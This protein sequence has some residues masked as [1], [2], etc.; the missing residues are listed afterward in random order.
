ML[1]PFELLDGQSRTVAL[2]GRRVE[3]LLARLALSPGE[4]VPAGL[5]IDDLWGD[6]PS[7]GGANALQRLVSRARRA[8][9]E[10]GAGDVTVQSGPGGYLLTVAPDEVDATVFEGLAAEGRRLLRESD[11]ARAVEPLRGALELW[12][13]VPLAE[14]DVGFAHAA[15][16]R[17]GELR[18]SATEDL[19]EA[20][21]RLGRSAEAAVELARLCAEHPLRERAAGLLMMALNASGRQTDALGA[22]E[23]IRSALAEELG[24]DPSPWLG[25]LHVGLLRGNSAARQGDGKE[26]PRSEAARLPARLARFVG[27][28]NEL[29]QLETALERSRLTT[30]FGSGGVGKTRLAIEY[31]T[32]L[33]DRTAERIRFVELAPLRAGT[34]LAETVAAALGSGQTLLLDR[35]FPDRNRFDQL[36]SVLSGDPTLLILDNCEHMLDDVVLFVGRILTDCPQLRILATSREPL[37]ITGEALCHIGPLG[38]PENVEDAEGAAAIQLFCDRAALVRPGFAL[39]P[40]TVGA[41]VEICRRLDGLPLAVEL[42]AARLRTMTVRQ[43]ADRLDDRFRLLTGGNRTSGVRHRTLRAVLDWSWD[44]LEEPERVLA[45][46]LSVMAGG[47]TADAAAVVCAGAGLIGDDVLYVLSSL[48]EKSLVQVLEPEPGEVRYRMPETTR[49][50]C[51]ERLV[52]AEELVRT[53]VACTA[54]LLELAERAGTGLHGRD[55][56]RLLALLDAEHD[57]LVQAVQRAVVD[58]DLDVAVRLCLALSWYWVMRGRYAE[59]DRWFGALLRF[60]DGIPVRARAVFAAT[61]VVIPVSLEADRARVTAEAADL[62]DRVGAMADHRL[63]AMVEPKCWLLVGDYERLAA[64]A[65]RARAHPDPWARAAGI[66]SLGLAAQAAG[67]VAAAERHVV[68]ALMAF[69]ELGDLWMAGQLI[70]ELSD[71]QSLRGDTLEAVHS[72]GEALEAVRMVGSPDDLTPILIRRG[73]EQLRSG[74]L[75]EAEA[76]FHQAL[77]STR[78][79]ATEHRI[80]VSVGLARLALARGRPETARVL[81]ADA[82]ALLGD[83]SFGVLA[84]RVE[85]LLQVAALKLEMDA[86]VP[87]ARAAFES[88]VRLAREFGDK[89]VQA[90]AAEV[91]AQVLL[92]EGDP[93]AAARTLGEATRL[94]G[95][96]DDG[97]PQVR[98]LVA[99]LTAALGDEG[100]RRAYAAGAGTAP[101]SC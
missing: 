83:A 38:V 23:R 43:V 93:Q 14:F 52:E 53:E 21:L 15:A 7:G 56:P 29:A 71:F 11:P 10:H 91:G 95:V 41:V 73:T 84:L 12:R 58:A 27:R 100:Y 26:Q 77:G 61:R 19:F 36:V 98:G 68:S 59:A 81:L 49:A 24:A 39:T 45:R 47:T 74:M 64:S 70:S 16:Q 57:N 28:R 79:P 50:Y 40:E 72:L 87:A 44:L 6:A 63:L 4:L 34:D 18:L 8:I 101:L 75:A 99:R 37:A 80:L 1:G 96:R 89:A 32:R 60:G 94:R 48:A 25:E 67:D 31:A 35:P 5:L 9:Q 22:Y 85:V 65:E 76:S 46:R 54:Y 20:E 2:G 62:A 97:S 17:L 92:A 3:T 51:R 78:S 13:G 33:R 30:L 66:A 55:Q 90:K 42:A 86:T 69:R 88:A 82:S